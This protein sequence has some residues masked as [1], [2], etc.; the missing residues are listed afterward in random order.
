MNTV[1][2]FDQAFLAWLW[3]DPELIPLVMEPILDW[4]A[5]PAWQDAVGVGG[6]PVLG[7]LQTRYCVHDLGIYPVARGRA[8]GAGRADAD[9][10]VG[11]DADHGRRLRAGRRH[12]CGRSRSWPSGAAVD[13]VGRVPA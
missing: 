13:S 12:G 11:R 1:D 7:G 5:S 2:I 9:R 6:H 3:L 4:C 8:P 10:G